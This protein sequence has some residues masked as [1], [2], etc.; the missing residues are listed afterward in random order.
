MADDRMDDPGSSTRPVTAFVW[1]R[2]TPLFACSNPPVSES[3]VGMSKSTIPPSRSPQNKVC[4]P[5]AHQQRRD[6]SK[7]FYFSESVRHRLRAQIED[8][9]VEIRKTSKNNRKV[10]RD[11]SHVNSITDARH[12]DRMLMLNSVVTDEKRL[13][14]QQQDEHSAVHTRPSMA[15]D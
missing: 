14:A 11:S 12:V 8:A 15:D 1:A 2:M 6:T 3:I 9:K 13:V 5:C 4:S 7:G 10:G